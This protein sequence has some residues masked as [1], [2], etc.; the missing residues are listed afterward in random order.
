VI[1]NTELTLTQFPAIDEAMLVV[2]ERVLQ[3]GF[4]DSSKGFPEINSL[5]ELFE[6]LCGIF[7]ITLEV[8]ENCFSFEE[9][10]VFLYV[11]SMEVY[12]LAFLSEMA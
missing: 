9:S 8:Y 5:V 4:N 11:E 12:Y 7:E 1:P 6:R 3:V 2:L 10:D